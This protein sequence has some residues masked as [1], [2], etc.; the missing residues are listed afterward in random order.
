MAEAARRAK[1]YVKIKTPE[2][3]KLT[4]EQ[5]KS[6]ETLKNAAKANPQK[7]TNDL[8]KIIEGKVRSSIPTDVSPEEAKLI[9]KETALRVVE[10]LQGKSLAEESI[11]SK[12]IS[13]ELKKIL[14]EIITDKETLNAFYYSAKS[15]SNQKIIDYALTRRVASAAFRESFT[16]NIF[17]PE[18]LDN[19]RVKLSATPRNGFSFIRPASNTKPIFGYFG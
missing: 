9:Y 4:D 18:N 16:D 17:R 15:V 7:L 14:P 2:P 6:I 5:A 1:L 8:S 12:T 11:A 10:N 13:L 3:T 19:V